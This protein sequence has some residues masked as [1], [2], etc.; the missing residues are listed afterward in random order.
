MGTHV[1][2]N[3]TDS[4]TL[5]QWL[6]IG[7]AVASFLANVLPPHLLVTQILARVA[8]DLRGIL[9]PNPDKTQRPSKPPSAVLLVLLPLLGGCA[10][11]REVVTPSIVECA[12]DASYVIENLAL[13]LAGRDAFD[14]LDG[15]KNEKGAEFVVCALE[16]FLARVATTDSALERTT[17][18]AYLE[19]ERAR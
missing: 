5:I 7:W 17:A 13:I 12:P 15:I 11:L 19:R 10:F 14:V 9:Q 4:T 2:V 18:Q 8:T 16:Q 1:Q 6:V 3:M